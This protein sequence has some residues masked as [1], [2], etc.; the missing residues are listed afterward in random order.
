M[1]TSKEIGSSLEVDLKIELNEENYKNLNDI[2]F[3]ELCI[4][5]S[6]ELVQTPNT[7]IKVFAKKA[8]GGKCPVCWK[9]KTQKCERPQ[10]G[11]IDES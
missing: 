11:L 1:R 4:T 10:C 9:L 8:E 2:D 5:S 3:A 6:A 7:E